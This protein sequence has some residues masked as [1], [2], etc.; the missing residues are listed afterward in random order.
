MS[1]GRATTGPESI[2]NRKSKIKNPPDVQALLNYFPIHARL[3][4]R[5]GIIG[6]NIHLAL[7]TLAVGFNFW[8]YLVEYQAVVANGELINR[9]M[10]EVT[11][12]RR[13]RG[14]E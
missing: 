12:M 4:A 3:D 13:E 14:L 10:G 6:R 2:K 9:I 11:R 7:A 5:P 1:R 8:S